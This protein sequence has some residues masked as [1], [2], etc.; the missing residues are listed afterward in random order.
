MRRIMAAAALAAAGIAGTAQAEAFSAVYDVFLGGLRGGELRLSVERDGET[1][2]AAASL[3]AA[4][5]AAW[6]FPGK[7][8]AH[9]AGEWRS[10]APAPDSFDAEG[11]FAGARQTVAM[12]FASDGSLALAADPPLRPRSYDADPSAL[13]GALDPLSAAVAALAP[14]PAA[15]VCD[16]TIAV[17]D[18]RRRFDLALGAAKAEGDRIRCEG[19][20]QRVAGYKAK[21]MKRPPDPFTVWWR[22]EDGVATFERAQAPTAFGHAVARRRP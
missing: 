18:S 16:R 21:H 1:Y 14:A 6:L 20:F 22:V 11:D 12:A 10:A 8:T 2:A 5:L 4:G 3:R 15:K 17:F 9:A 13:D 19:T 7:A